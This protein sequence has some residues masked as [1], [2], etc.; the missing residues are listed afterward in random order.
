MER[1]QG[2]R[3]VREQIETC[4]G[5]Q[6]NGNRAVVNAV[7]DPVRRDAEPGREFTWVVGEVASEPLFDPKGERIPKG[8]ADPRLIELG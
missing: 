2:R 5:I 8:R 4:L 3:A 6:F 7:I 1:A